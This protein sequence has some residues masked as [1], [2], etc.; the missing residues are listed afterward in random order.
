MSGMSVSARRS[1]NAR[2][3]PSSAYLAR[4]LDLP[5]SYP[6]YPSFSTLSLPHRIASPG[7]LAAPCRGNVFHR[8]TVSHA[9]G[10]L[11][12]EREGRR[13]GKR[14]GG[15]EGSRQTHLMHGWTDGRPTVGRRT[16]GLRTRAW[17]CIVRTRSPLSMIHT[18]AHSGG[19]WV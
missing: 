10:R 16:N 4:S 5:S 17:F 13:D 6:A 14:R 11:C 2:T 12:R 8:D 1:S 19:R 7:N 9:S 3:D 18:I 15:S